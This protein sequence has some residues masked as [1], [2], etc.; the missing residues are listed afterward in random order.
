[1][2][3]F[4]LPMPKV[5]RSRRGGVKY[6]ARKLLAEYSNAPATTYNTDFSDYSHYDSD[7]EALFAEHN[8]SAENFD[9]H[10]GYNSK[11]LWPFSLVAIALQPIPAISP[12]HLAKSDSRYE[13][14]PR[15]MQPIR[16]EHCER[17]NP[18]KIQCITLQA[19]F[20]IA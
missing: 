18:A 6:R 2:R 8:P 16:C 9:R 11:A 14:V 3:C 17:N 20:N 12:L 4:T 10:E 5:K 13:A 1:M 7:Y 15:F 19:D